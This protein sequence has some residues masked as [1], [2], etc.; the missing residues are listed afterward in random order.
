[1]VGIQSKMV[2]WTGH[3]ALMDETKNAYSSLVGINEG[4][5]PL[6]RTTRRWEETIKINVK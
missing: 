1:M 3:V 2:R 6:G 4:K 5:R